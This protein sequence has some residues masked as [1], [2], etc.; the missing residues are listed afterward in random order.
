MTLLG[1]KL[2]LNCVSIALIFKEMFFDGN[3]DFRWKIYTKVL[4]IISFLMQ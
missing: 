4:C 3:D 2:S 1:E